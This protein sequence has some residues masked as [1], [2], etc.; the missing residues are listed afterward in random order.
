MMG[1]EDVMTVATLWG[2]LVKLLGLCALVV[3]GDLYRRLANSNEARAKS[4]EKLNKLRMSYVYLISTLKAKK[5]IN[6]D[7]RF[8][9]VEHDDEFLKNYPEIDFRE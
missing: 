3:I 9:V 2:Y 5:L 1:Q 8:V 4:D 7:P 6:G